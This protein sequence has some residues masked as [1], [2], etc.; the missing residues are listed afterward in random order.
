MYNNSNQ[1]QKFSH[2]QKICNPSKNCNKAGRPF[3][4]NEY[5]IIY[6]PMIA[7]MQGRKKARG[8]YIY[9]YT[10]TLSIKLDNR[11]VVTIHLK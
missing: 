9:I 3:D 4:I 5:R 11:K 6:T 2:R 8:L 10:K 7:Q 1:T